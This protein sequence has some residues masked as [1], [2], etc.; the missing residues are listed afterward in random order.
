MVFPSNL[1]VCDRVVQKGMTT[2]Y[3]RSAC[4]GRCTTVGEPEN[5][6]KCR[7]GLVSEGEFLVR[8]KV[9]KMSKTESF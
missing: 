7:K 3:Y 8:D 9:R 4:N 2:V 1:D 5:A 6:M